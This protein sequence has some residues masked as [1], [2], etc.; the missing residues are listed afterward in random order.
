MELN[1]KNTYKKIFENHKNLQKC[2]EITKDLMTSLS[3]VKADS[4][5]NTG[6]IQHL[7]TKIIRHIYQ[8]ILIV[9][10]LSD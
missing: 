6:L 5:S 1:I 10:L 4:D 9:I 7:I 3:K 8:E 2:K